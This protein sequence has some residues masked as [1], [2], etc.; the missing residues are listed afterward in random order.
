MCGI[1]DNRPSLP[2]PIL[3]LFLSCSGSLFISFSTLLFPYGSLRTVSDTVTSLDFLLLTV[4][5]ATE[6]V[7]LIS[8]NK[9]A[10]L[11]NNH[12]QN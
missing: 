9:K 10:T 2:L 1:Q 5:G 7:N 11:M 3:L 4:H 6:A 8:M 12:L